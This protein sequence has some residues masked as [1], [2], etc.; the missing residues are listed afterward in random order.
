MVPKTDPKVLPHWVNDY[1]ALNA[2]TIIDSHP[3]PRIDDVLADCVKGKIWSTLDMTDTFFQTHVHPDDVHLTAVST[4]L[5]L[6]EWLVMTMGLRN[7]LPI[8]QRHVTS[9]LQHL[10]GKICHIYLDDIVIWSNSVTEH[11]KHILLVLDM[12][13]KARLYCNPCK[14]H[15]YLF[16][17]DF[18][19]HHVLAHGIKPNTI[20]VQCILDWPIPC[21]ASEVRSFLGLVWYISTFLPKIAEQT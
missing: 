17:I 7:T 8:H 3:L 12:L 21:S 19:G 13:R 5:G 11:T 14:C 16:D 15:F 1:H 10:I 18:L 20:K 6:Y 4:P 9:A 2:N